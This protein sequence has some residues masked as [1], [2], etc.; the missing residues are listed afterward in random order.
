MQR[1]IALHVLGIDVDL[2]HIVDDD[3][4][5]HTCAIAQDVVEHRRLAG[6]EE[7]RKD[8]HRQPARQGAVCHAVSTLSR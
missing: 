2:A 6:T 7:A 1:D 5:P 3:R 8:R 4:Y